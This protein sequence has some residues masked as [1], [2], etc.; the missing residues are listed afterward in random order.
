MG[1]HRL[2]EDDI[3]DWDCL[4]LI[5]HSIHQVYLLI[6][7]AVTCTHPL[8]IWNC[9]SKPQKMEWELNVQYICR[10]KKHR[11]A[12]ASFVVRNPRRFGGVCETA[13]PRRRGVG[14]TESKYVS[15][16]ELVHSTWV[17]ELSSVFQHGEAFM[18]SPRTTRLQHQSFFPLCLWTEH[19]IVWEVPV[20]CHLAERVDVK[21]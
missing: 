9:T 2:D 19:C 3:T 10:A 7:D 14:V 18:A 13:T 5:F 1:Y 4:S 20:V 8:E 12:N 6:I 16:L 15:Y 11:K 21:Y 17:L